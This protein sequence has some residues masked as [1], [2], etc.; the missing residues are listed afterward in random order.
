MPIAQTVSEHLSLSAACPS[1]DLLGPMTLLDFIIS[2][3]SHLTMKMTKEKTKARGCA[4]PEKRRVDQNNRSRYNLCCFLS[5]THSYM[6]PSKCVNE[7]SYEKHI[8]DAF[9]PRAEVACRR[10]IIIPSPIIQNQAREKER[11][12]SAWT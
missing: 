7:E 5:L 11:K 3:F 9:S 10:P 6:S 12:R 2:F 4:L 8:T 1:I